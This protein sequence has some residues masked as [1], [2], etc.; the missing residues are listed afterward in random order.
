[1]QFGVTN[2]LNLAY[3]DVMTA[4]AFIAYLANRA[5]A[6]LWVSL[7]VGACFG[8]VASVLL[9]RFLYYPF[10]RR[11]TKLFGMIVVTIAVALILQNSVLAIFGPHFFNLKTPSGRSVS[12]LSMVF[13]GPQLTII[14]IAIAAMLAIHALLTYTKL[15]KAMRA[16]A[17][18]PALA[19]SCGIATD[20]VIDL[21][22]L[23]SGALCGLAGVVLVVNTS[24]F[25]ASTGSSFL[26]P[27]VA[28]AILGGVGQPY[29]AMLGAVTIGLATEIAAAFQPSYKDVV[30]FAILIVVL[31]LRPQG[32][33]SEVATAKE[34]TA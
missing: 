17:A 7:V 24:S 8:A 20:R 25:T 31:L 16:T 10:V 5:G 30:A 13:T 4:S 14:G 3:G 6:D 9:N 23:I 2:I 1:M 22:W 18:N 32:I 21:A 15:G 27:I 34:V 33:L 19:R 11:G 28:A 29:G 26:V 12:V